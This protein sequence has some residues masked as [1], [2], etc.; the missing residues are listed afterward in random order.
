MIYRRLQKLGG[1][2]LFISLPRSWV[3]SQGLKKGD[4]IGIEE[5]MTGSVIL[6][7]LYA[8]ERRDAS[9]SSIKVEFEDQQK[10]KRELA[11]AYLS[12]KEMIRLSVKG[13]DYRLRR[14]A[15][16]VGQS[17]LGL[18]LVDEDAE[19]IIF[20]FMLEEGGMTP[21][22]IFRR[23]NVLA[24]SIY[25]DAIKARSTGDKELFRDVRSRDEEI[26]RLYFLGVR[27]LRQIASSSILSERLGVPTIKALDY[28]VAFHHLEYIG[29][30]ASRLSE[31]L[32]SSA[33]DERETSILMSLVENIS[34]LQDEAQLYFLGSAKEPY[35][36]FIDLSTKMQRDLKG[37]DG[38]DELKE[39]VRL[40]EE[41]VRLVVDI[42][43]LASTLYPYI[44]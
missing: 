9:Y 31:V 30:I 1:G 23:M 22:K 24:K 44:R 35:N 25:V 18:Q 8:E 3:N 21:E 29:D 20:R 34:M 42:A 5:T 10:L 43:D 16:N 11:A 19:S 39:A 17:F 12:G 38:K 2:T 6:S 37:M 26:D 28:R 14:M 7:P 4:V 13:E 40:L 27:V 32:E 15:K 33:L 36:T 41:I